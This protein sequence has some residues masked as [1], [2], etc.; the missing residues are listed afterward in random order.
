MF[1]ANLYTKKYIRSGRNYDKTQ[2][3]RNVVHGL[4]LEGW[5]I[6]IKRRWSSGN[7]RVAMIIARPPK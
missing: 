6:T 5:S 7:S 4:R 2:V 1:I 3:I